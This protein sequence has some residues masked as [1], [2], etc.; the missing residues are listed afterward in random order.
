MVV[1]TRAVGGGCLGVNPSGVRVIWWFV[2]IQRFTLLFGAVKSV[3]GSWT[4][5]FGVCEG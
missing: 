2:L 4:S 1:G 3:R 5:W